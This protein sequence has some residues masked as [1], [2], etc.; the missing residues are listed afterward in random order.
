MQFEKKYIKKILEDVKN[1]QSNE[2]ENLIKIAQKIKE[3]S[4]IFLQNM[5]HS[6][7]EL[8]KNIWDD[9]IQSRMDL[10]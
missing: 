9:D 8:M 7:P 10:T 6:N 5:K 1:H 3:S 4:Q 2:E